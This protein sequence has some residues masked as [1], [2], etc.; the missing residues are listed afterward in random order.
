L[1]LHLS[2]PLAAIWCRKETGTN[3]FTQRSILISLIHD[4]LAFPPE[5][6]ASV[7]QEILSDLT[8]QNGG[9]TALSEETRSMVR[10]HPVVH[11]FAAMQIQGSPPLQQAGL[12]EDIDS[13]AGGYPLSE[14][15]P[16]DQPKPEDQI[17]ASFRAGNFQILRTTHEP[18]VLISA[19]S[20]SIAVMRSLLTTD[21][22][23]TA[24]T[25]AAFRNSQSTAHAGAH[26]EDEAAGISRAGL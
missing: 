10:D 9:T 26:S 6:T 12:R 25:E 16:Q 21:H 3:V 19:L 18:E 4:L 13:F 1:A 2:P 14:A 5:E 20:S 15:T 23:S 24:N 22:S 8:C 11:Y 7:D 17:V